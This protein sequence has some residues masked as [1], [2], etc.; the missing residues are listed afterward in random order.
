MKQLSVLEKTSSIGAQT[1]KDTTKIN[2]QILTDTASKFLS[3]K[4]IKPHYPS[5]VMLLNEVKI[6]EAEKET[7]YQS[8]YQIKRD[9]RQIQTVRKNI[10]QLIRPGESLNLEKE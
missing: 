1:V 9:W 8:Y 2:Y 4:G 5:T 3:E 10:D 7:L 6:L